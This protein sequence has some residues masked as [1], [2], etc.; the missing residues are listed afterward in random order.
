MADKILRPIT[1]VEI[2]EQMG[3]NDTVLI[4]QG[5][6]IKRAK[7]VAGG[8]SGGGSAGGDSVVVVANCQ[9]TGMNGTTATGTCELDANEIK[10]LMDAGKV[11]S[12]YFTGMG[13]SCFITT[14]VLRDGEFHNVT[15]REYEMVP[16][17]DGIVLIQCTTFNVNVDGSLEIVGERVRLNYIQE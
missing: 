3:E 8:G 13:K 7:G 4:E 5:G 14:Q 2:V 6:E 1:D 9:I 12:L 11:V 15:G 17:T 16:T 10:A